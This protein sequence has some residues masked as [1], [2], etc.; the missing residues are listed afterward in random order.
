MLVIFALWALSSVISSVEEKLAIG[1]W[2][3]YYL[4]VFVPCLLGSYLVL[5]NW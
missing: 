2:L 5:Q 1:R 3:G 4:F